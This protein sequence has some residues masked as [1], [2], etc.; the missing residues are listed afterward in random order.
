MSTLSFLFICL[1]PCNICVQKIKLKL[2][3]SRFVPFFKNLH[4][5][6][7]VLAYP[8][9]YHNPN[10]CNGNVK[11]Q[12]KTSKCQIAFLPNGKQIDELAVGRLIFEFGEIQKISRLAEQ[13]GDSNNKHTLN[14]IFVQK[15]RYNYTLLCNIEN[16]HCCIFM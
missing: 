6:S 13:A 16:T 7:A 12:S 5:I 15:S 11:V 9:N 2:Y 3:V 8:I 1:S 4:Y 10:K 14:C